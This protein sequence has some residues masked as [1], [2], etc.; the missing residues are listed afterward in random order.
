MAN[1]VE[2]YECIRQFLCDFFGE[3]FVFINTCKLR[4][5]ASELYDM[6]IVASSQLCAI[7]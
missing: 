4:I 3:D 2:M 7:I 6:S 1:C 5:I